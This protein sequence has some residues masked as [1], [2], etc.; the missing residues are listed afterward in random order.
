[1]YS[2]AILSSL[3]KQSSSKLNSPPVTGLRKKSGRALS[4]FLLN[5]SCRTRLHSISP[6]LSLG[7]V[8]FSDILGVV[9]KYDKFS[10]FVQLPFEPVI[11]RYRPK[12]RINKT[13][14]PRV[15]SK[16]YFSHFFF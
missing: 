3:S 7:G 16:P 14:K 8:L 12:K 9:N 6:L 10:L 13:Q 11:F 2:T 1:M 15:N 5:I 4:N